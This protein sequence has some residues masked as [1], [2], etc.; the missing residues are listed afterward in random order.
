TDMFANYE[1][2]VTN[3]GE[4]WGDKLG[5]LIF[6]TQDQFDSVKESHIDAMN[7]LLG[8]SPENNNENYELTSVQFLIHQKIPKTLFVH[9]KHDSMTP[10]TPPKNL[11]AELKEKGYDVDFITLNYTDHAF[12]TIFPKF[13]QPTRIAYS[14]LIN[15]LETF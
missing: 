3:A 13:S 7:D 14:G 10:Y 12:D 11:Y 6:S 15:W 9:G 8:G 2:Y 5:D 4:Q 1:K